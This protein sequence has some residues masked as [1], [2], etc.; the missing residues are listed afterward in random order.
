MLLNYE[1]FIK[2]NRLRLLIE[3]IKK[4][5]IFLNVNYLF[6]CLKTELQT[7]SLTLTYLKKHTISYNKKPQKH[8][9]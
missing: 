6:F 4:H 2:K 5:A 7:A 1:H 9:W 8:L 3:I